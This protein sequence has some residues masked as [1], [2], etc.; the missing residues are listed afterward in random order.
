MLAIHGLTIC[1]LGFSSPPHCILRRQSHLAGATSGYS[2]FCLFAIYGLIIW[3]GGVDISAG[4][5]TFQ[6]ML[7]AFLSIVFAAMGLAQSMIGFPDIGKAKAAVQHVFPLIDRESKIDASKA[8][9]DEFEGHGGAIELQ[10]VNFWYPA[11]P[12]IQVFRDFSLTIPAGSTAALVGESGSGK[13]TV[14]GL[15]ERFYDPQVP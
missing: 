9:G 8:E 1:C 14:V 7:V 12:S 6:D 2:E 10:A 3:F 4:R 5:S 13:S 15:I 11:R